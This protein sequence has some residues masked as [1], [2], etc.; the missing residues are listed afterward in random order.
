MVS[1]KEDSLDL[2]KVGFIVKQEIYTWCLTMLPGMMTV[3]LQFLL[4]A[5]LDLTYENRDGRRTL[6]DASE[7]GGSQS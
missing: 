6:N 4:L 5:D 2:I 7:H 3:S 1:L